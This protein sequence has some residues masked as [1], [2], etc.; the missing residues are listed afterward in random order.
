MHKITNIV[1]S[2]IIKAGFDK[3]GISTAVNPKNVNMFESWLI[4]KHN[5]SMEWMVS[6][7]QK[8]ED[9]KEL[10][11]QAK[12]V[13]CVAQNYYTPFYHSDNP[14]NGK[15]SR[16]ALGE[17]Y[18][19]IIKKKLKNARWEMKEFN[20]E[21]DGRICVDTAPIMEKLWAENAGLGWQGKNT[22]LITRDYGS[23]VF[24]G[25]IVI[26]QELI[27]DK[28]MKNYCGEC[29]ACI[30]ACPTKALIEPYVLDASKCISY[31]TI[32]NKDD[33][34]PEGISENFENWIFGCDICQDVCPWNRFQKVTDEK[35][36][37]P[38]QEN[39]NPKLTNLEKL[40]E[41]EYKQRFKKS[42]VIRSGWKNFIRNVKAVGKK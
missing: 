21:L 2:I 13:I 23:W 15:I 32:E 33:S 22:N 29:T 26:N 3:V 4:N 25:E 27:P 35:R 14:E 36:Y 19:K 39:I 28:P 42:P 18:H 5:G 38:A 17:D 1:K 8:R 24:L 30:D 34:F 40:K 12:S 7:K 16:Y 31:L 20:P 9:I 6:H 41:N 11:P 10:Y 37:F